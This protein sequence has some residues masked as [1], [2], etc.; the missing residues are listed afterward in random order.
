MTGIVKLIRP[1]TGERAINRVFLV[2]SLLIIAMLIFD[3][4][5]TISGM[6][7]NVTIGSI[8]SNFTQ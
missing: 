6:N 7:V 4:H 2:A 1:A 8:E 3:I 5:S